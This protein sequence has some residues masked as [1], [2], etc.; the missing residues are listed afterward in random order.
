MPEDDEGIKNQGNVAHQ[1]KHDPGMLTMADLL[2][3]MRKCDMRVKEGAALMSAPLP[4]RI[5][6]IERQAKGWLY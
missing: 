6:F 3:W 5:V 4:S 1:A 2:S